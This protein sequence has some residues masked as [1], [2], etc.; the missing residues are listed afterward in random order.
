MLHSFTNEADPVN[1]RITSS[2]AMS[3]KAE[4]SGTPSIRGSTEPMRMILLTFSLIGLTYA[5]TY[6]TNDSE[7]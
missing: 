6:S 1:A 4:W 7:S 5:Y 2:Y 3:R